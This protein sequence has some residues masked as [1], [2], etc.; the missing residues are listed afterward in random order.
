MPVRLD[1]NFSHICHNLIGHNATAE[2]F[3]F[4][5]LFKKL[6]RSQR[7]MCQNCVKNFGGTVGDI[8][9]IGDLPYDVRFIGDSYALFHDYYYLL[10]KLHQHGMKVNFSFYVSEMDDFY[11]EKSKKVF[12]KNCLKL[13][14]KYSF[15]Q[16]Q[17]F[18]RVMLFSPSKY[19]VPLKLSEFFF[20]E[21]TQDPIEIDHKTILHFADYTRL[22]Q[23]KKQIEKAASHAINN[24]YCLID[25]DA[26]RKSTVY[27]IE[28][29][30]DLA[31]AIAPQYCTHFLPKGEDEEKA[32]EFLFEHQHLVMSLQDEKGHPL[33]LEFDLKSVE[34]E[35]MDEFL[36]EYVA[37]YMGNI[38]GLNTQN[39]R[40]YKA[41]PTHIGTPEYKAFIYDQRILPVGTMRHNAEKVVPHFIPKLALKPLKD[42]YENLMRH[43]PYRYFSIEYRIIYDKG[44]VPYFVLKGI[45]VLKSHDL[46]L[47]SLFDVY[48]KNEIERFYSL[49]PEE[50]KKIFVSSVFDQVACSPLKTVLF[51]YGRQSHPK[52]P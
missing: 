33:F 32:I 49:L 34:S 8:L 2:N 11:P 6:S 18:V 48:Q 39:L 30:L 12:V 47:I 10:N 45:D 52:Q 46:G 44:E 43:L 40:L 31:L 35:N 7:I 5:F 36:D 20:I 38:A 50:Y 16:Q 13:K 24:R 3:N 4:I 29:R 23:K 37:C 41:L 21:I 1:E 9:D 25:I 51:Q 15:S 19:G 42:I 14:P 26:V 27:P 17:E 28:N 22:C